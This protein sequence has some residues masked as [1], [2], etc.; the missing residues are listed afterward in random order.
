VSLLWCAGVVLVDV[1]RCHH[2]LEAQSAA[3]HVLCSLLCSVSR[4]EAAVAAGVL[5]CVG[6][7][8]DF[9]ALSNPTL[10]AELALST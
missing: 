4:V 7:N 1:C 6:R 2:S 8:I 9:R 3:T 5:E 10:A